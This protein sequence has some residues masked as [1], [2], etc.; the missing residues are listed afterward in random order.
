MPPPKSKPIRSIESLRSMS[1]FLF[2]KVGS[3]G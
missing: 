3:S 1:F 2:E